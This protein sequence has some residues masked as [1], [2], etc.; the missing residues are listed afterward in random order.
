MTYLEIWIKWKGNATLKTE[1]R[2]LCNTFV[3]K[4]ERKRPIW[5]P[6]RR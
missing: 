2:S 4:P 6:R 3:G 5:R 1:M